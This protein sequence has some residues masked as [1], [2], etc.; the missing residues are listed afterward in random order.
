MGMR[1]RV[2][3]EWRVWRCSV[4]SFCAGE[5]S[6]AAMARSGQQSPLPPTQLCR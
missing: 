3:A 1:L 6:I 5:M 2:L 4:V